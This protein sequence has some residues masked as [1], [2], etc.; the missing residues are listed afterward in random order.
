[1]S[2]PVP[3]D[4]VSTPFVITLS[5]LD[6]FGPS[7]ALLGKLGVLGPEVAREGSLVEVALA[8]DLAAK[9]EA[10]LALVFPELA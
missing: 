1:M 6:L 7:V 9:G 4:I 10:V 5:A 8:A 2:L 3:R